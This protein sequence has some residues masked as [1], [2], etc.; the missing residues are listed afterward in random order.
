MTRPASIYS[1][2]DSAN[3]LKYLNML[4]YG[5]PGSGKTVLWGTGG[6]GM[7]FMDSDIGLESAEASGNRG[8]GMPVRNY[9]DLV[10]AYEWVKHEA[11]PKGEI[12][13]V[14][15]DSLSLFQDR[16]LIDDVLKS[17]AEANP[18]QDPHVASQRE[19]L[20]N[21]N[22]IGEFVRMF[23][24]L[25]INF[26]ISAHVLPDTDPEDNIIYMPSIRG[27]GMPSKIAGYM[28]IVAY[29]AANDEGKRRLITDKKEHYYAKDRFHALRTNGQPYLDK[30]TIKKVEELVSTK[31]AEMANKPAVRRRRRPAS[32]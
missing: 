20:V 30:P 32:A 15:W 3:E 4:L 17:A 8:L 28:N 6:D 29:L 16:A 22:R 13:W 24:D 9:D 23:V 26:G 27:K 19:Y 10:E 12:N 14:V 18:R 7:F 31:R 5:H 1:L 21:M 25:P 11:I 2:G